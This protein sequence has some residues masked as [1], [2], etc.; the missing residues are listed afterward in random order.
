MKN[1]VCLDWLRL[2]RE[3]E[4]GRSAERDFGPRQIR[5]KR[6]GWPPTLAGEENWHGVLDYVKPWEFSGAILAES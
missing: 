4:A 2:A 1:P 5:K 3:L 6:K